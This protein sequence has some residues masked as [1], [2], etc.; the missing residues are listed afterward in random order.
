MKG[1][2]FQPFRPTIG[3]MVRF[4]EKKL[5]VPAQHTPGSPH[6]IP[7]GIPT[8]ILT[9]ILRDPHRDPRWDP[10]TGSPPG[11]PPLVAATLALIPSCGGAQSRPL[12]AGP[13]LIADPTL[14]LLPA[15]GPVK[16][17]CGSRRASSR[18]ML[19]SCIPRIW[20]LLQHYLLCAAHV[21]RRSLAI[22]RGFHPDAAGTSLARR[23]L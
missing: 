11:A 12:V 1:F 10:H 23:L 4:A 15:A 9:G 18:G 22:G 13:T 8:G 7:T 5:R 21:A 17:A 2:L 3:A 16:T 14:K 6:G 20:C 19:F